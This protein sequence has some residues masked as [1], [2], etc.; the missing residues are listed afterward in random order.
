MAGGTSSNRESNWPALW[1]AAWAWTMVSAIS[2]GEW[3]SPQT[4]IP[5]LKKKYIEPVEEKINKNKQA[6]EQIQYGLKMFL[7]NI[8]ERKTNFPDLGTIFIQKNP[9]SI[10]YPEDE[11]DL[12][13]KLYEEESEYVRVDPKI[14]KKKINEKFKESGYEEVPIEGVSI[15]DSEEIIKFRRAKK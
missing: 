13:K 3:A 7:D 14:D 6:K 11:K 2:R 15:K 10:M 8:N 5:S 12:A 1:A 9:K 4:Y